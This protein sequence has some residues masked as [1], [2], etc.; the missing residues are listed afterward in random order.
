[1]LQAGHQSFLLPII[2]IDSY[3][4]EDSRASRKNMTQNQLR[5][6]DAVRSK[7]ARD[8]CLNRSQQCQILTGLMIGHEY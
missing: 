5:I 1:M 4:R 7:A 8:N 3:F 6:A 2:V